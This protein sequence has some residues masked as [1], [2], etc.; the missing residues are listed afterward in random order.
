MKRSA[1]RLRWKEF[2]RREY[3][4]P[5]WSRA[6][7]V[8]IALIVPLSVAHYIGKP[9]LGIFV[10]ITAQLIA[11]TKIPGSYAQRGLILG[12]GTLAVAIAAFAGTLAG[13]YV[14][15]ALIFLSIVVFLAS[16]ARGV[17]DYGIVLGICAVILFLISLYPPHD[18]QTAFIRLCLTISGGVWASMLLLFL[19][20]IRPHQPLYL[21][22]VRPWEVNSAILKLAAKQISDESTYEAEISKLETSLRQVINHVVPVLKRNNSV[23]NLSRNDIHKIVGLASRFGVTAL[24]L[25]N[26]LPKVYKKQPAIIPFVQHAALS[27]SIAVQAVSDAIVSQRKIEYLLA[28]RNIHKASRAIAD[29]N[30]R[31]KDSVHHVYAEGNLTGVSS[32]LETALQYLQKTLQ[33]LSHLWQKKDT[34][35][36]LGKSEVKY[37]FIIKWWRSILTAVQPGSMLL[38]HSLRVTLVATAG[39]ALYYFF[40]IPRGHWIVLTVVVLLQPDFGATKE[41]TKDRLLG[42]LL[43]VILGSFLLIYSFHFTFLLGAIAI[44]AFFFVYLQPKNYKLSVVFVTIMLVAMLETAEVVDWHIAAYRLIATAIGGMLAV[45]AAYILWPS[46]ESMQFPTVIASA[47]KANKNYLLQIEHELKLDSGFHSR[48]IADR[49]KAEVENINALESI[50]R[51]QLEPGSKRLRVKYAQRLTYHNSKLTRELTSFV[52]FLPGLHIKSPDAYSLI[53]KL[54]L[55]L[56]EVIVAIQQGIHF[57]SSLLQKEVSLQ[58]DQVRQRTY[59]PILDIYR[60]ENELLQEEVIYSHLEKITHEITAIMQLIND[61][62]RV[63]NFNPTN[64]T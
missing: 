36:Y 34:T 45:T 60:A 3:F 16:L 13:T 25:V 8:T 10:G 42:T 50:K 12:I 48:L 31:V 62:S 29:L 59:T 53:E 18:L 28:E 35:H 22:I 46:W 56:E 58:L 52:A 54:S 55:A 20:P 57:N 44:C 7:L 11:S 63:S 4:E 9:M 51:I 14:W 40:D 26:E 49:R 2:V 37:D 17:G 24:A 23:A 38:K 47:I 15:T 30:K 41:K 61:E 43:G 32:L 5:E 1:Q 64:Q 21:I 19:W 33:I 27:L 6:L 39:L